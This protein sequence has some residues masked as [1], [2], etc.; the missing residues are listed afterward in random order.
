MALILSAWLDLLSRQLRLTLD[1][2]TAKRI[3]GWMGFFTS[4]R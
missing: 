4:R 2:L 1:P 3:R